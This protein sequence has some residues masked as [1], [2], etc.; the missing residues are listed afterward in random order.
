MKEWNS[1][2]ESDKAIRGLRKPSEMPRLVTAKWLMAQLAGGIEVMNLQDGQERALVE[3]LTGD[4][5]ASWVMVGEERW[6]RN[7][8][9][10]GEIQ[11]RK[12]ED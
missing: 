12:G 7:D 3:M 4:C 1:G 6:M 10:I 2:R 11:Q 8:G 5:K 9:V